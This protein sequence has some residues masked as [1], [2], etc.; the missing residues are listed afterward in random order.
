MP[1][2]RVGA[3]HLHVT[4]TGRGEPLILLHGFTGSGTQW[5]GQ[6]EAYAAHFRT[7]AVDLLGHGRS[8]APA[9][10]A[11]YRM[12]R[13]VADLLALMDGLDIRQARWLGYS[14]GA[15]VA[16]A[17]ALAHPQRVK[18]LVLEGGSPGIADPVR[19]RQ[20]I[21]QDEALA[22]R[23]ERDGIEAF[24]DMWMRQPLFASQARLGP[25]A[26]AEARTARCANSAVGLANTLRGLGT[27]AQEPLWARLSTVTAPTLLVVGEEDTKFRDI[28]AAMLPRMR[29]ATMA[30]I[31]EAGHAAHIENPLAFNAC[32]LGFL[33]ETTGAGARVHKETPAAAH[34]GCDRRR[35]RT[36]SPD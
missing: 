1:R 31:P 29:G 5:A 9:D 11:R 3:V 28:A 24:V 21:A 26:L 12:E 36:G 27:G 7:V 15:R 14:M 18:A 34:H 23:L 17:L 2:V 30:V 20:R 13:C 25:A 8:D 6:S 19:R 16:L 22:E 32:V 33:Q 35:A 10:P 4:L